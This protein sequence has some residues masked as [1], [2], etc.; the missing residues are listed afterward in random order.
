LKRFLYPAS[1]KKVKALIFLVLIIGF[2]NAFG[3]EPLDVRKAFEKAEAFYQ[4]NDYGSAVETYEQIL[5]EGVVSASLYY[6]L[7]NA[8]FKSGNLG[9]AVLNYERALQFSPEDKE[10]K[11]NLDFVRDLLQ[12]KVES[13]ESPHWLQ[14]LLR[15]PQL[16]TLN[17]VT[18]AS[19][20]CYILLLLLCACVVV[21][22]PI[23]TTMFRTFF[24]PLISLF[25]FFLGIGILKVVEL[26]SSP[27]IVTLEQLDVYYGPSVHETKAFVLHAGTKCSIR[28]TSGDWVLIWLSND[29]G[30]WVQRNGLERI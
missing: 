11:H 21:R 29:R 16:L 10:L 17:M 25:A 20:I 8:Y 3:K 19:S 12:D 15:I 7:G 13:S 14:K 24:I 4:K 2:S 28:Q 27:A 5:S 9:K 1:P 18:A 6:N 22:P 23:R 26:R 30:G